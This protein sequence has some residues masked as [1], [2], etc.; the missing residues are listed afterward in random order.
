MKCTKDILLSKREILKGST[1][2]SLALE[3]Y[4]MIRQ[5]QVQFRRDILSVTL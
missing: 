1:D 2:I 5:N 4:D 3:D